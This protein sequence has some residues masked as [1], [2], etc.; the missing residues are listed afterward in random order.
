VQEDY[1]VDL[2]VIG[3]GGAAMAARILANTCTHRGGHEG[4][5]DSG[6]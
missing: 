5:L 4:E 1:D 6:T 2:A 3:S